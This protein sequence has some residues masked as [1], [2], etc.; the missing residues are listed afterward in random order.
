VQKLTPPAPA[1]V[2]ENNSS[3]VEEFNVIELLCTFTFRSCSTELHIRY[4]VGLAGAG[5]CV[6][7]RPLHVPGRIFTLADA[8]AARQSSRIVVD[9]VVGDLN[10]MPQPCTKMPP[11]PASCR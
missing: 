10:V 9:P 11:P 8:Y 5:R 1:G 7:S 4:R 6:C 3:P 2:A